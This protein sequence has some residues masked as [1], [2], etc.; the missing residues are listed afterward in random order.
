MYLSIYDRRTTGSMLS[1]DDVVLLP[2]ISYYKDSQDHVYF[3]VNWHVGLPTTFP[4]HLDFVH[5]EE[6]ENLVNLVPIQIFYKYV[7]KI[8]YEIKDGSIGIKIRYLNENGSLKAT[9]FIKKCVNQ[10]Y[11][12]IIMKSS[13]LLI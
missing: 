10:F 7:E 8:M 12:R 9:K 3:S 4:P 13:R 6:E 1:K 11:Q 5:V 2:L